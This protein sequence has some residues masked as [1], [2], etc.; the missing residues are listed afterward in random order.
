M[1]PSITKHAE[2]GQMLAASNFQALQAL[3]P[4]LTAAK[5]F[6][7]ITA[8][9]ECIFDEAMQGEWD[10]VFALQQ[11]RKQD[12]EALF[13]SEHC[14]VEEQDLGDWVSEILEVDQQVMLLAREQQGV[15]MS[16]QLSEQNNARNVRK[17]LS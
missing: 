3:L 17:Y 16:D 9:T 1:K 15:L 7:D 6:A 8:M 12:L 14:L 13:N 4:S 10:N 2:G 11:T 5:A